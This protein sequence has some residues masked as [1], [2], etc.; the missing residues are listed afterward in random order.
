MPPSFD[1]TA[2]L[3]ELRALESKVQ[4]IAQRM[5]VIERNEQIIG[6]TLISHNKTLKEIESGIVERPAGGVIGGEGSQQEEL[7][8]IEKSVSET[9]DILSKLKEQVDS[10][11]RSIDEVKQAVAELKFLFDSLNPAELVT[12]DQLKEFLA[13]SHSLRGVRKS[14]R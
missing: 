9:E 12:A 10:N 13:E 2:L 3:A 1:V 7:A 14:K 8:L 11:T 6:R 4:I 5:N